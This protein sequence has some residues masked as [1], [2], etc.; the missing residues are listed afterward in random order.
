M[1][2]PTLIQEAIEERARERLTHDI[3]ALKKDFRELM[4]KHNGVIRAVSIGIMS[5]TDGSKSRPY[6]SQIFD[7]EAVGIAIRKQHLER[8]VKIE[9][10]NLLNKVNS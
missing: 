3:E 9:I 10:N 4:Q 2:T 5:D 6:L 8:Y 7:C 1:N